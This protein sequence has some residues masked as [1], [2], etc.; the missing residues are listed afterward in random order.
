MAL[1]TIRPATSPRFSTIRLDLC[2]Y[3]DQPVEAMVASMGDDLRRIADEVARIEL[4][5]EGAVNFI[6]LRDPGLGPVLD[7]LNVRFCSVGW[8]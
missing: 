4:E 8:K 1:S 6:V 2:T 3:T 7:A 5:F